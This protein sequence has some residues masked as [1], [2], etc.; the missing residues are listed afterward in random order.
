M[1]LVNLT[2]ACCNRSTWDPSRRHVGIV[3]LVQRSSSQVVSSS[4]KCNWKNKHVEVDMEKLGQTN[5]DPKLSN[6][7]CEHVDFFW[8]F[9]SHFRYIKIPWKWLRIRIRSWTRESRFHTTTPLHRLLYLVLTMYTICKG[10]KHMTRGLK[11]LGPLIVNK[12]LFVT[13]S[14]FLKWEIYM[15]TFSVAHWDTW[16][17][18]FA[19]SYAK[20]EYYWTN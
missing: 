15:M 8:A 3:S 7:I 11:V 14:N 10:S 6:T 2:K 18:N 19:F 4:V 1:L 16:D 9:F 13:M 12:I 20:G 17:D 5:G